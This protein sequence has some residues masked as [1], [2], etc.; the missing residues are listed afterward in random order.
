MVYSVYDLLYE[1]VSTTAS[2][3]AERVSDYKKGQPSNRHNVHKRIL[4]YKLNTQ[5]IQTFYHKFELYNNSYE[6][7]FTPN[8]FHI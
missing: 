4:D 1:I 5:Y 8:K 2:I 3:D 6:F 7:A